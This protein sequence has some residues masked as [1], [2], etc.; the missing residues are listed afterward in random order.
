MQAYLDFDLEAAVQA[1]DLSGLFGEKA[2]KKHLEKVVR[3][4]K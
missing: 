3:G 2:L 1:K 4:V